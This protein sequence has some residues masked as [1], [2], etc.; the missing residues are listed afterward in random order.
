[1]SREEKPPKLLP[2][3][4]GGCGGRCLPGPRPGLVRSGRE[5][6]DRPRT[7]AAGRPRRAGAPRAGHAAPGAAPLLAITLAAAS[8]LLHD[9][10]ALAPARASGFRSTPFSAAIGTPAPSPWALEHALCHGAGPGEGSPGW[11]LPRVRAPPVC[12]LPRVLAPPC[13]GSPVCRL[14]RA[15]APLPPPGSP[16][17]IFGR[18]LISRSAPK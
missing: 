16:H 14:P 17:L 12:G 11:G 1:M 10:R 13:A 4:P 2:A 5:A 6:R 9:S 18:K 15:W 7:N 8:S 3:P